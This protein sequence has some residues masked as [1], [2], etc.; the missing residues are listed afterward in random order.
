MN[1]PKLYSHIIRTGYRRT[2]RGRYW[3]LNYFGKIYYPP[4]LRDGFLLIEHLLGLGSVKYE[5]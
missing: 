3:V 1:K 2:I 5:R 4:S